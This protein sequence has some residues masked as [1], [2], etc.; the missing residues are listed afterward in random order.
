MHYVLDS[1]VF[2]YLLENSIDMNRLQE[3][4]NLYVTNVQISEISNIPKEEIKAPLQKLV[5]QIKTE[6]LLLESGVWCDALQWDDDQPWRDEINFDCANI[7]GNS[8]KSTKWHDAL[9][10]EVTKKNG[11]CLVT[12]DINFGNRA[13]RAGVTTIT[14]EQLC[15][16]YT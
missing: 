10:G 8:T 6:K 2:D 3:K 4:C 11:Y 14:A 5:D 9:I 15:K 1:N 7:L 13:K 12:N 16:K